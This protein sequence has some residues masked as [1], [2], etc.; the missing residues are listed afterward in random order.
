[1][2]RSLNVLEML[3]ELLIRILMG[4]YLSK[5]LLKDLKILELIFLWKI[6]E[7]SLNILTILMRKA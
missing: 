2:K 6:S 3:S 1:L 7:E 5:N 4:H